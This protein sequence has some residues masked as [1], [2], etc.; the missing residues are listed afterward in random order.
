MHDHG[1]PVRSTRRKRPELYQLLQALYDDDQVTD[2]LARHRI[3][4]RAQPGPIASRFPTPTPLSSG[5]L[6][7]AYLEL[8]LSARHIELL[9]GQPAEQVLDALHAA[10]IPV[11]TNG[12]RSPWLRATNPPR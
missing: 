1:I 9:T 7:D 5:L 10:G 4:V 2:L 8:G 6:Y 3:P 11:R 12:G